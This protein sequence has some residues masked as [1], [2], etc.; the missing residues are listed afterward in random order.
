MWY[1]TRHFWRYSRNVYYSSLHKRS[2]IGLIANHNPAVEMF[3]KWLILVYYWNSNQSFPRGNRYF[4]KSDVVIGSTCLI[5]SGNN[6]GTRQGLALS[7]EA[8]QFLP[9]NDVTARENTNVSYEAEFLSTWGGKTS[10]ESFLRPRLQRIPERSGLNGKRK[11]SIKKT[12]REF[13]G[14]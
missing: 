6:S 3:T 2:E 9:V 4:Q 8:T 10:L 14:A 5:A 12:M 7:I 13:G 11:Q 1:R